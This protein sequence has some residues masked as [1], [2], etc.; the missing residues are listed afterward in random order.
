MG[1]GMMASWW[2]SLSGWDESGRLTKRL[3]EGLLKLSGG[4]P[5]TVVG[6]FFGSVCIAT[7]IATLIATPMATLRSVVLRPFACRTAG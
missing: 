2:R 3:Q 5:R 1:D 6:S 7:L 4:M